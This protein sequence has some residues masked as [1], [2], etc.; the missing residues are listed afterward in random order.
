M[1]GIIVKDELLKSLKALTRVISH[2]I[3]NE[4]FNILIT[5]KYGETFNGQIMVCHE[6]YVVDISYPKGTETLSP[7]SSI[8]ASKEGLD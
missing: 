2:K 3:A 6:R 1:K 5:K 4:Y 7:K 8:K